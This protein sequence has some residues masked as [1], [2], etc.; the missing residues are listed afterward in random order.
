LQ[1]IITD[2]EAEAKAAIHLLNDTR[3]G[4]ATFLPLDALR[5]QEVPEALRRAARQFAGVRGSLAD[6]VGCD[7][8]LR[9]AINVLLARVLVVD[10]LDTAT[11]VARQL[12]GGGWAKIVTLGGEVVVP[13]VRSRAAR[14]TAGPAPTCWAA[15]ARSPTWRGL[16]SRAS[17]R[18]KNLP[19]RNG[20]RLRLWRRRARACAPGRPPLPARASR[21]RRAP[22]RAG[23][24]E[25][26]D[27]LAR[28]ADGLDGRAAT[29]ADA[30]AADRAR[31]SELAAALQAAA[32][33]MR[34]R[35]QR[36]KT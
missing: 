4:R 33:P 19:T 34:A 7:A 20:R 2:S 3:G 17:M 26:G 27:R 16:L 30:Q 24:G 12:D 15:N 1:D 35:R 21:P 32:A 25:R 8:D 36:A 11:P 5:P 13:S 18:P 22:P 6:L 29:L 9:P 23:Q 31:E 28:E 10:D 14:S